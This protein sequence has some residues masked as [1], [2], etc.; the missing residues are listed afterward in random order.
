MTK[1]DSNANMAAIDDLF[2]EADHWQV[3]TGGETIHAKRIPGKWRRYK[4]L[5]SSIYLLFFFGPYL[6]WGDR[7]AI[8]FDIPGRQFHLLNVT[9]LPQ[10]V[11]ILSLVLLFL[12]MLLFMITAIAGRIWCGFF[13]FQT[14]WT[15]VYTLIEEKLE[16]TPQQRRKLDAAPYTLRKVLTKA[17]KHA[18]WLLIAVLTGVSFTAWFTDVFGLW[19][20]LFAIELPV[21]AIVTILLFIAGTYILAGFMR[22]Q[23]CMWLC[24]YAR[25]QGAMVDETTILPAYDFRRGEPRGRIHKG[26]SSDDLGDCV[27]CNQCVAV[28][29]PGIDIRNG[30]QEGC[31]MCALCLDACDAVMDKLGRPRGLIRF[32]SLKGLE[33]GAHHPIYKRPRVWITNLIIL[34]AISGIVYGL[35]SI[36]AIEL[37][38]LHA[39]QPLYVLQSDGSI[40][41]KY[42]LKILNKL[43]E[44]VAVN[45]SAT[46]PKELVISTGLQ[47]TARHGTVTPVM[48]LVRVPRRNLA[49]E[50]EPIMFRIDTQSQ[51]QHFSS[52]RESIFIGP[53]K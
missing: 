42:T 9:I 30:Q 24:P 13:C 37:K 36:D 7:Q 27:D 22:E 47:V 35:N 53:V 45:I 52:R 6:R 50:S 38:V 25:I 12:A 14:A 39:R 20:D 4:W 8:L 18:L 19:A 21:P 44:D 31:I 41:N 49:A 43:A 26:A 10:D 2:E 28:C 48:V 46:G 51:Q 3:N 1:L 34:V 5:G 40:Q 11:W 16:G 23:T 32:E 33:E 15:D 29:P 17:T